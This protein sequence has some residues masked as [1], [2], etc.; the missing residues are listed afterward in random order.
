MYFETDNVVDLISQKL[1]VNWEDELIV[2]NLIDEYPRILLIFQ[3][4]NQA[5]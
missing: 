1:T 3:E 2:Q 4:N 5:R